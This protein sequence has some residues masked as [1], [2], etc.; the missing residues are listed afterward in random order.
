MLV[1]KALITGLLFYS[2]NSY[3]QN[4]TQTWLQDDKFQRTIS[5]YDPDGKAFINKYND[6][7]GSPYF[8]DDWKPCNITLNDNKVFTNV[9]LKFDIQAQSIHYLNNNNKEMELQAGLIKEIVFIDSANN[10]RMEYRFQNGFPPV[11]NRKETDF[12]EVLAQGKVMLLKLITKKI[13]QERDDFSGETRSKFI[14]SEEYYFFSKILLQ[15][16]RRDKSIFDLLW[17]KK[18]KVNDYVEKNKLSYKS[19]DDIKKII[20]YYNTLS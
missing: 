12:Y 6:I 1:K 17:D 10:G 15:K 11:N 18:D 5:V 19:I 4:G 8:F 9:L 16:V 20:D 13:N 2:I 14:T 7:E 3:A